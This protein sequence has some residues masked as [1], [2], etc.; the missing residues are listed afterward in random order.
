MTK[1]VLAALLLASTHLAYAADPTQDFLTTPN[2]PLSE[3]LPTRAAA[4]VGNG[5]RVTAGT[6]EAFSLLMG[7]MV[8][9]A[10]VTTGQA[11]RDRFYMNYM[12]GNLNTA[13]G[14]P[15]DTG[16]GCGSSP[17]YAVARHYPVGDPNDLHEIRPH[18]V[19]LRAICSTRHTNCTQGNIYGGMIRVPYEFRPGMIIKV[20]YR[21]PAAPHSWA[22]VWL[23]SGSQ[24]SPG[25]GGNPYQ[26]YGT[27]Q[28]LL[29]LPQYGAAFEVD[30]NDNYPVWN[31]NSSITTGYQVVFNTP[32]NYG[33]QFYQAPHVVYS[34]DTSGYHFW[35]NAEPAFESLP[36]PDTGG[37]HNL[38][39]SWANDGSNLLSEFMDGKLLTSIYM[40]YDKAPW[41]QD[42]NGNWKQQAMNLM[43]GNQA[44]PTWL[45]NGQSIR[46]NDGIADGWTMVVQ[47]ISAWNGT[48]ANPMK[49][50]P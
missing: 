27:Q 45:V 41:Y 24:T 28:T 42:A 47:E 43:I 10:N 12:T 35:Q 30:M 49:Y 39:L 9:G 15:I 29:Q 3:P 32:A 14:C 8:D 23:F 36:T 5:L 34:A 26:G 33:V 21:S 1:Y 7:T 50:A 31:F 20:R 38:V 19:A 44:V 17:F 46:E 11:V 37:F 48:I 2:F 6:T 16:Q 22:P 18:G 4:V 25:P 13:I 40:E